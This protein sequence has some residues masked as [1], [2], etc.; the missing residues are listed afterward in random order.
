MVMNHMESLECTGHPV[1]YVPYPLACRSPN[2]AAPVYDSE[3]L[4]S[5]PVNHVGVEVA[6]GV[7]P[8]IPVRVEDDAEWKL[9]RELKSA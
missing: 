5:E 1:E 3:L 7:S 2:I 4:V 9:G 6:L 8:V